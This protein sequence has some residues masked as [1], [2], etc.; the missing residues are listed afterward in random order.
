MVI[1]SEHTQPDLLIYDVSQG[2]ILGQNKYTI[3]TNTLVAI[4]RCQG[5]SCH[6]YATEKQQY[7]L[8]KP[9]EGAVKAQSLSL[10]ENRLTH[11]AG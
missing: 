10:I 2:S 5:L 11:I 8:F 4:I 6:F 3:Y 9:K 1:D 7:I